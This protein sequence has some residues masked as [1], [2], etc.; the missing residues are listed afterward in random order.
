MLEIDVDVGRLVALA[1]DE[2]L[3]QQ[4]GVHRVD[5]GDAQAVADRRI[6]RRAATL[7]QDVVRAREADDVVHG[8]EEGL[9]AQRFDQDHLFLDLRQ[10]RGRR[11]LGV[12]LARAQG[13]ERAQVRDRCAALGHQF[14]RVFVAQLAQAERAPLGD[15]QRGLQPRR[16]V[17][18]RQPQ[19]RAQML[20]GVA[21]QREAAV[22]QGRLQ[23][24]GGQR[25]LHRLARA[26]VHQHI[27]GG[28]QR[29]AGV[30][31]H[32]IQA[33]DEQR[34]VGIEQQLDGDRGA[35]GKSSLQPARLRQQ[36]L[37]RVFAARDQQRVAARRAAKMR[38]A[39]VEVAH[40][41]PVLPFRAAQARQRD[42]LAQ[43]AIAFAVARNQHQAAGRRTPVA[44]HL[45]HTADQQLDRAAGFVLSL[46]FL[47]RA[48]HAGDRAFIGDGNGGVAQ[49]R[50]A[51]D[52]FF[53]MRRADEEAEVRAAV[54][55]G[56]RR[57]P[58][59]QRRRRGCERRLRARRLGV[60]R[61]GHGSFSRTTH[62]S[63]T[64]PHPLAARERPSAA[65]GRALRRRGSR[66]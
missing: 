40:R 20:L 34:I 54:Q 11:A 61:L 19:A 9:V 3:E 14:G 21:R 43:I 7:A 5:F 28:H 37:G 4:R 13:G 15:A 2:A 51:R 33:L 56:I 66:G 16:P 41:Q 22:G 27:A 52:E 30:A 26:Q 17:Q 12:A 31:G 24:H 1:R 65:G 57:Q 62:A 42:Q 39:A 49:L 53:R 55:L 18:L 63:T 6:G 45:E 23:A 59:E 48:H 60:G 44:L 50:G 8:E 58:I 47:V 46:G 36:Q 35:L 32:G 64:A 10:N 38:R 29:Q 25:V